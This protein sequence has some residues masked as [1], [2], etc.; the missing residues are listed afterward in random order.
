M[1]TAE[2][3]KFAGMLS[4]ALSQHQNSLTQVYI[5]SVP[6]SFSTNVLVRMSVVS[7]RNNHWLLLLWDQSQADWKLTSQVSKKK[8]Q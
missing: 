4:A 5:G 3:P 7:F 8:F 6:G 2:F 1:A